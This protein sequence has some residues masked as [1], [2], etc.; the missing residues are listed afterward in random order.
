MTGPTISVLM[1]SNWP[2]LAARTA[3]S[4]CLAPCSRLV[5][6]SVCCACGRRTSTSLA[7]ALPYCCTTFSPGSALSAV[8]TASS[9]TGCWNFR[10]T[11]VPP[12]KSMPSGSPLRAIWTR[13]SRTTSADSASACQRHFVKL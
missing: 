5:P 10:T 1:T 3:S 8:R 13:P 7:L 12:E 9:D 6:C 2:R 4:T 11:M